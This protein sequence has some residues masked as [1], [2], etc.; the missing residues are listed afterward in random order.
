MHSL[1]TLRVV[2]ATVVVVLVT[3]GCSGQE[4]EVTQASDSSDIPESTEA[5]EE[6]TYILPSIPPQYYDGEQ[7]LEELL[8]AARVV[9]R[10]TLASASAS[11]Y[12]HV[13]ISEYKGAIA[14][15]FNV[16]EYL[17]GSG[18]NEITAVAWDGQTEYTTS[19]AA[20]TRGGELLAERDTQWENREALLFLVSPA[21]LAPN[22]SPADRYEFGAMW[23]YPGGDMYSITSVHAKRWRPEALGGTGGATGTSSEKYFL[24][25]VPASSGSA[26]GA[27]GN[28]REEPSLALSTIKNKLATIEAEIARSDNPAEYRLCLANVYRGERSDEY[29]R[30][31]KGREKH[32]YQYKR[33]DVSIS[34]GLRSG[35]FVHTNYLYEIALTADSLSADGEGTWE[36]M[37]GPDATLFSD[38][39]PYKV[40]T[41]RPLA[42]GQYRFY[43]GVSSD[44]NRLCRP[45]FPDKLLKAN[46]IFVTV[47][48]PEGTLHETMFDPVD[49]TSGVGVD[50]TNGVISDA[51]LTVGGTSTSIS[52]LK[53]DNSQVVL[54]W[55]VHAGL[56][57]H[58]LDFIEL[59]G[60]VG[61]SL[62]GSDAT[63]DATARTLTWAVTEQPWDAGDLLMLRIS[64][65]G[66]RVSVV[67]SDATPAENEPVDFSAN[68]VNAPSEST[69]SYN[70]E[71]N[72]GG[73]TWVTVSSSAT[74]RYLEKPDLRRGVRVTVSY[75]SGESQTSEPLWVTWE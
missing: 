25:D 23:L 74:L 42:A 64:A 62:A 66:F 71:M 54:S 4:P 11:V 51:D 38:N 67:A 58:K 9:I 3:I 35:Q 31:A 6:T 37:G 61:L 30:E 50:G 20:L 52:G 63:A 16:L 5:P 39:P 46:E 21:P 32:F 55:S 41:A 70:W 26:S 19:A 28:S 56:E 8:V 34:S 2:L 48:A 33:F 1:I 45:E 47:T 17:K 22:N 40:V 43:H 53:W 75:A 36:K 44:R 59:D 14:Y 69:P 60:S 15:T 24:T 10:V 13:P 29:T 68:I 12:Y 73:D 7:T 72:F 49:L 65:T 18:G 27:S 57:G